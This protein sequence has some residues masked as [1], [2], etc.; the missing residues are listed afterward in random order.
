[1]T[2]TSRLQT[3]PS[4]A[5]ARLARTLL[6]AG[7]L[8]ATLLA[9]IAA[10]PAHAVVTTVGP[11]TVGL[12][13]RV[14][15][16]YVE[17][18]K[19]AEYANPVGNP[20]LHHENMYAIYW[21]PT[22]HYHGDWQTVIDRYFQSAGA[23][24]TSGSLE[25]FAV[26]SQYTDTSNTPA[27]YSQTYEGSYTDTKQY[28]AS[29]CTD[30]EP[31]QPADL[32]GP[33]HTEVCLTAAQVSAELQNFIG[34]HNLPHGL[35]T[36]YFVLLPP[37]ATV[38]LDAGKATGHCSDFEKGSTESYEHSFCSYH[39]DVNPGGLPTGDSSTVLYAVLPWSAGG[40]A[41]PHLTVG[42]QKATEE[43]QDAGINPAGEKGP[44]IEKTPDEQQPNQPATC[45]DVFDGGCDTGLADLIVNQIGM[46]QVNMITN[47]LLGSWQDPAGNENTDECRF[48][49]GE[50]KGGSVASNPKSGAGTLYNEVFANG[51]YYVNDFFNRAGLLLPYPGVGCLNHVNLGPEFTAPNPVNSGEIVGFN[52]MDS[53]IAL[54]AGTAYNAKGE[55]TPTYA[56]Y[57][58]NF[59]DG[60]PV[61]NGYAPGAPACET[62]WL[63]PCAASVYHSYQY[64][65]TY[66]VTLTVRDVGGN[67]A[68]V[69]NEVTVNGPAAPSSGGGGGGGG[70]GGT[71]GGSGGGSAS[72]SS[73][74]GSSTVTGTQQNGQSAG[75]SG[76]LPNP[77]ASAT[78]LSRRLR[79]VSKGGVQVAYSVNEQVAGHFE[80][81]LSRSV[82]R[83]L[84]IGGPA[85]TGLPAGSAPQVVVAKAI[86]VTTAAG[87]SKVTLFFSKPTGERLARQRKVSFMLRL[88]VH[89]AAPQPTSATALST[90]TLTR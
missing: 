2:S 42:D 35:T 60:T 36:T 10:P 59:G 78:V 40:L 25:G 83:R 37:G 19:P 32:I 48:A 4:I 45:P 24:S 72:G 80:V 29:A 74:S 20:V 28:P 88:V 61:V 63:S 66:E 30:P 7:V 75:A 89:N 16:P 58:W 23:A 84:K 64:G 49:F 22:D 71:G 81:L 53:N 17:S 54:D 5:R 3:L 1:V 50:V 15:L 41:D 43:C 65:G 90:F 46:E 11:E 21:D 87:H 52:G 47:P 51:H 44:E 38:C 62:P 79:T 55:P 68:T 9:V 57:A 70:G 18:S 34:A 69:T 12:Q 8:A 56:T 77:V 31:L 13:P 85:A 73:G 76:G 86:V 82:A 33:G 39:G 14:N 27:S 26:A 67:V 6:A